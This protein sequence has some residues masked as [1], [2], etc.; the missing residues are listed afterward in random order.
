MVNPMDTHQC[1]C[2]CG[3]TLNTEKYGY[4][5]Y[6]LDIRFWATILLFETEQQGVDPLVHAGEKLSDI[7]LHAAH[8]P[9]P[10][11]SVPGPDEIKAA[12]NDLTERAHQ[13]RTNLLAREFPPLTQ[14]PGRAR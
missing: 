4:A 7:L 12:I 6:A 2:G 3:R 8:T 13:F 1:P 10:T 11:T 14:L 9:D 5:Q